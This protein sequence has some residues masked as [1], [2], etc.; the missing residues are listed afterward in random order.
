MSGRVERLRPIEGRVPPHDLDAEGAV[1]SAALLSSDAFD[2][3]QNIVAS[4][5]FYSDANR[6]VFEALVKVRAEGQRI[7]GVTVAAKLMK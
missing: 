2:T 5:H 4:E 3:I 1:L 7:D 6:R